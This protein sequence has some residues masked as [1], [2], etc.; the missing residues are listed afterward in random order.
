[1]VRYCKQQLPCVKGEMEMFLRR[2]A[3]RFTSGLTELCIVIVALLAYPVGIR[4]EQYL[5]S[6]NDLIAV[7]FAV[8]VFFV[9]CGMSAAFFCFV[10]IFENT[11]EMVD[12][13][14]QIRGQALAND[15]TNP[16]LIPNLNPETSLYTVKQEGDVVRAEPKAEEAKRILRETFGYTDA[17]IAALKR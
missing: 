14:K 13:L 15:P 11:R 1:M 16:P 10:E 2:T 3:I 5:G 4:L 8:F 17:E 12:L 6:H 7:A 9:M